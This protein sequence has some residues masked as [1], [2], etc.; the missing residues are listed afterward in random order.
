MPNVKQLL[1][2]ELAEARR[3]YSAL[4]E[5]ELQI[6]LYKDELLA[7]IEAMEMLIKRQEDKKFDQ[8]NSALDFVMKDLMKYAS[9]VKKEPEDVETQQQVKTNNKDETLIKSGRINNEY[10]AK[11]VLM[12]MNKY[13]NTVFTNKEIAAHLVS[14]HPEL[15]TLWKN[16]SAAVNYIMSLLT[17]DVN[18]VGVGQYIL[19]SEG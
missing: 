2:T 7:D 10:L 4:E 11:V 13:P 18:K 19:K 6:S 16:P 9:N 1:V 14:A 8:V 15:K 3:V 5:I 17:R 12:T